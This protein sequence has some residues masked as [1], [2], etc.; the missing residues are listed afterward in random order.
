MQLYKQIKILI[1]TDLL[2]FTTKCSGYQMKAFSLL[3]FVPLVIQKVQKVESV[4]INSDCETIS[5]KKTN[6]SF[7]FYM[8]WKSTKRWRVLIYR[9]TNK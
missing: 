9:M 7:A 8:Q 5:K 3:F 4:N 1:Y 6:S 2:N